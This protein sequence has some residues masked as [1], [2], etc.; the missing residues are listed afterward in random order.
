VGFQ[1]Y[2]SKHKDNE[3]KHIENTICVI[4]ALIDYSLNCFLKSD[5]EIILPMLEYLEFGKKRRN[6]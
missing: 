3:H 2:L 1:I 6:I 4:K 5:Y